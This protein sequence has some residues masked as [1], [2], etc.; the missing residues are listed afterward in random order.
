[1]IVQRLQRVLNGGPQVL[2]DPQELPQEVRIFEAPSLVDP[3]Q[4]AYPRALGHQQVHRGV[5][6]DDLS[7][8]RALG[9]DGLLRLIRLPKAHVHHGVG[10]LG[11]AKH[12]H[13]VVELQ[14]RH[15]G[16]L[17]LSLDGLSHR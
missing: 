14:A 8:A 1:M 13:R 5:R 3:R 10:E 11:V 16:D 15:V 4:V 6:V 7:L 12:D 17:E 9:E 2:R